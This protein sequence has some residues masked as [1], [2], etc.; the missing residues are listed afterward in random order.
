MTSIITIIFFGLGIIIGS[1]LNVV[2]LRFNTGRS[3]NGR[4]GCM[5]CQ[6][7]LSWYELIPLFSFLFIKGKCLGCK[8]KIS[9]QYPIVELITGLIF[10]GIFLKFQDIFYLNTLVFSIS[11]AYYAVMFSVLLIIAVYDFKHKIIPDIFSLIFGIVTFVGLFFFSNYLFYPHIPTVLELLSGL[12]L[13]LP[14]A[15]LWLVSK[16][17]WMGLGDAK[18]SLGLGWLLGYSRILSGAVVAFWSGAIVGLILIVFS[19]KNG[20][21]TEIPFAPFLVLGV[22]IAFLFELHLFPIGF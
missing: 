10:A 20:L 22:F 1:F 11:Y 18:L 14:F 15:F 13:A 12:F 21:K 7:K 9:I 8:S 4:S 5:T 16:G 2:I 17:T 3:F 6:K 19:K